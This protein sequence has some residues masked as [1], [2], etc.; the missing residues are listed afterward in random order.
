MVSEI[1][2]QLCQLAPEAAG[3]LTAIGDITALGLAE[4][5]A[6]TARPGEPVMSTLLV[7]IALSPLASGACHRC[8][9]CLFQREV[10]PPHVTHLTV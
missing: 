1:E 7:L 10:Q 9:P 6:D 5:V 8:V 3:R 4:I 2:Q